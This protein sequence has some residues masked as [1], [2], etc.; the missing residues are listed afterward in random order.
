MNRR[1][2]YLRDKLLTDL[3]N[4]VRNI[5]IYFVRLEKEIEREREQIKFIV[6]LKQVAQ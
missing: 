5:Y 6:L 3:A 2:S 1:D 4:F